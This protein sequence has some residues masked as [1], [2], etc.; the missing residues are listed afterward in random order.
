MGEWKKPVSIIVLL[1][2]IAGA[3]TFIVKRVGRPKV[4]MPERVKQM[5]MKRIDCE[6]LEIIEL[7]TK[8]WMKLGP[9]KDYRWK[10]P[11]TGKYTM[12]MLATC[13]ACGKTI[14]MF[15]PDF[16]KMNDP[17]TRSKEVQDFLQRYSCPHCGA[18]PCYP[19][20]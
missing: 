17:K 15:F 13:V 12:T 2:V 3:I 7:S 16:E 14:P 4:V 8:E 9:N 6:T 10:N 18:C 1:I 20:P 11:K 19:S 5:P